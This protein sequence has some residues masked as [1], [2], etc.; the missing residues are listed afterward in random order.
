MCATSIMPGSAKFP[1]QDVITKLPADNIEA[2]AQVVKVDIVPRRAGSKAGGLVRADLKDCDEAT[3]S[4]KVKF[5]GK[6]G[7]KFD[8]VECG[9]AGFGFSFGEPGADGGNHLEN[10]GS[11]RVMW[12]DNAVA[13]A[14]VYIPNQAADA[15][16]H[17]EGSEVYKVQGKAF[18]DIL[19]WTPGGDDLW[20]DAKPA[21]KFSADEW[22]DVTI[23]VKLNDI[24]KNNGC[25]VVTVNG[26]TK[27]YTSMI[28]RKK[29]SL[30][31]NQ[32]V[33]NCWFGGGDDARYGS[34]PGQSVEF[35]DVVVTRA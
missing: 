18:E 8:F 21:M 32:V 14:Y 4:Y 6:G 1:L 26:V 31:I 27:S 34:P 13:V 11:A 20:R 19:H 17:G 16:Y 10:G 29:T 30:K 15:K 7:K 9:K 12:R 3:V 33:F 24:G 5:N 23:R 28:W 2:D 22:N 25:I 35:K